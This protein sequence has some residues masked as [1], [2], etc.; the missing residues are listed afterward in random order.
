[1]KQSLKLRINKIQ[2]VD[3]LDNQNIKSLSMYNQIIMDFG[4]YGQSIPAIG[5]W[6]LIDTLTNIN[7]LGGTLYGTV[8]D[9]GAKT[10]FRNGVYGTD[11]KYNFV[12]GTTVPMTINDPS[13]YQTAFACDSISAICPPFAASYPPILYGQCPC[14]GHII[15]WGAYP[16]KLNVNAC[17]GIYNWTPNSP[18]AWKIGLFIN[19]QIALGDD[20]NPLNID[21]TGNNNII[22]L[23]NGDYFD[24]RIQNN[25]MCLN[26]R[27]ITINSYLLPST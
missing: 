9:S 1:M 14:N 15:Y 27:H 18:T 21:C 7:N 24:V 20:G 19:D 6:I 10:F 8:L 13:N 4:P 23:V 11:G 26:L 16:I 17:V 5:E 3:N 25:I 12:F 22:S 2:K